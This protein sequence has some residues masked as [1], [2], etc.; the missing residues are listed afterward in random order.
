MAL[1]G[2]SDSVAARV[3]ARTV[4]V[5]WP[6]DQVRFVVPCRLSRM[7]GRQHLHSED[8][9]DGRVAGFLAVTDQ[10]MVYLART[11]PGSLLRTAALLLA[12]FGSWA[13]WA[14]AGL[15]TAVGFGV[16]WVLAALICWTVEVIGSGQLAFGFDQVLDSDVVTR[17]LD[18]Y[19]MAPNRLP[20]SLR[21]WVIRPTDYD[22]VVS[23]ANGWGAASAA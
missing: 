6:G 3:L 21:I 5:R 9:G 2:Y 17:R 7:T 23:R 12:V 15:G 1:T 20:E 14:S 13:V 10:R 8:Q 11:G 4:R 18:A 22:A 19:L 16:A